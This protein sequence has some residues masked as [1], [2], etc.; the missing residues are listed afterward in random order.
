MSG[1]RLKRCPPTSK[2]HD[3]GWLVGGES[4][5]GELGQ[6]APSQANSVQQCSK[7]VASA[8]HERH[9]ETHLGGE[10]GCWR[11]VTRG[12]PND[13]AIRAALRRSHHALPA[14]RAHS[15]HEWQEPAVLCIEE[16]KVSSAAKIVPSSFTPEVAL[17]NLPAMRGRLWQAH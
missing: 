15:I 4:V 17:L 10:D 1:D 9:R 6:L 16:R 3:R 11:P 13:K 12:T 7:G 2:S 14:A 8:R 5:N